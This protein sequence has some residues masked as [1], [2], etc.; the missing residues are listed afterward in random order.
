LQQIIF[1][2]VWLTSIN[3]FLFGYKKT[4]KDNKIGPLRSETKLNED[5]SEN[6]TVLRTTLIFTIFVPL[7]KYTKP[8]VIYVSIQRKCRQNTKLSL[9]K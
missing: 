5:Q 7:G 1:L 9:K 3:T 4:L 6:I 8:A 2:N